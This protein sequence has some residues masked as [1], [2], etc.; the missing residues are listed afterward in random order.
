MILFTKFH[1]DK[2][3]IFDG[4]LF[5]LLR[6]YMYLPYEMYLYTALDHVT[7]MAHHPSCIIFPLLCLCF[8]KSANKTICHHLSIVGT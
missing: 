5:F 6:T 7:P 4:I 1:E 3:S 8:Q 2:L